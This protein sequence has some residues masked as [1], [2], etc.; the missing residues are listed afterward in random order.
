MKSGRLLSIRL[1]LRARGPVPATELAERLEVSVRT[2]HR[3]IGALSVH[4]GI[5]ALAVHRGI[6]ALAVHRGIEVLPVHRGIEAFSVRST[7]RRGRACPGLALGTADLVVPA[8]LVTGSGTI[9]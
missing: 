7:S 2:I 4:R 8:F 9:S 5:E 3:G 6:E 1:L